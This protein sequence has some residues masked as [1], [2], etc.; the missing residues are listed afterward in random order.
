MNSCFAFPRRTVTLTLSL[1]ITAGVATFCVY[2]ALNVRAQNNSAETEQLQNV[3]SS[4]YRSRFG[5][6]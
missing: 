6:P 2:H 3:L 4:E 5:S 1:V